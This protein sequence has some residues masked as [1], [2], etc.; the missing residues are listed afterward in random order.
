MSILFASS[1]LGQ[2]RPNIIWLMAEDIGPDIECYGMSAVKTPHLNQLADEGIKYT[3]CFCTNPISSPSRSAMMTGVHQLKINAQH[4]RS[5]RDVPLEAPCRPF[6]ALLR[7]AGYTCILGNS[8]VMNK[9]RKTDVN[10]RHTPLGKWDG[11]E[12]FG[13]FDKFD[14]FTPADQPFFAQ[15]QLLVTHRGD[16]WDDIHA[17]SSHPV[18]PDAVV[19]PPY[20]ADDPV[21]RKDWAKYLDQVEYMDGEVGRLVQ[22]LKDKGLYENTVIV[23][24]GDNGRCNLR[25]KGFLFDT[26]LHVP[27]II[28]G[29]EVVKGKKEV[30]DV[31]STIDITASILDLA[32]V[33]IPAYMD[34]KPFIRQG[35]PV[36]EYAFSA[37]DLWDEVMDQ[38]RSITSGKWKY[39]LN[40]MDYI[41]FDAHY[42]YMEFYRPAIHVMR[43]LYLAGKLTDNQKLYF[44]PYKPR[45]QLYDLE[46]DPDELNNL[47]ENGQY[48]DVLK[49]LRAALDREVQ[50]NTPE[51]QVFHP[52]DPGT[53]R[54][55]DFVRYY[56]PE[57]YARMLNGEEIGFGKYSKLYNETNK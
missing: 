1:V 32:G 40:V 34:G 49:N 53:L 44:E 25:G 57:A 4:H 15:I 45:E 54:I 10:F 48:Q 9:G 55:L 22:E 43:K 30:V 14:E 7:E 27:L 11:R 56:H 16:W 33:Q 37:R 13:L 17:K 36:R 23:F 35:Q 46:N 28:R 41:P 3:H 31:V 52:S 24:I 21:I 5:N 26:G 8:H 29:P 12:N 2:N 19:L 6:T 20:V 39:I 51:K 38:S 47:A 18:N 50:Y 42:A